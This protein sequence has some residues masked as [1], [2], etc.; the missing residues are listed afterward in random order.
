[1][2]M[3]YAARRPVWLLSDVIASAAIAGGFALATALM[4]VAFPS[5]ADA[6]A[7]DAGRL[8]TMLAAPQ[9][10]AA[11]PFPARET[12]LT[13]MT[14]ALASMATGSFVFWRSLARDFERSIMR[15]R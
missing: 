2:F 6:A 13:L 9:L 5:V 15:R 7:Q 1:M 3:H 4:L 8:A 10:Q 11:D 12:L 14:I